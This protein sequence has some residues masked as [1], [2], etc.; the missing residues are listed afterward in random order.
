MN[1]MQR[2]EGGR[3]GKGRGMGKKRFGGKGGGG[4][5]GGRLYA[6]GWCTWVADWQEENREDR[7]VLGVKENAEYDPREKEEHA[8][9][10]GHGDVW[11]G[12]NRRISH[13]IRI[14]DADSL[15]NP[16]QVERRENVEMRWYH[17]VLFHLAWLTS[18]V[19]A[20]APV[21]RRAAVATK[22]SG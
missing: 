8:A 16:A 7:D 2:I 21:R 13:W 9:A 4:W 22:E 14:D 15:R 17:G 5:E 12:R 18:Y 1:T 19:R 10:W 3:G 20:S 11:D 6:T